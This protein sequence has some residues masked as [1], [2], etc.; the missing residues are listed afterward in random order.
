MKAFLLLLLC[1]LIAGAAPANAQSNVQREYVIVSG[2]PSLMKWEKWKIQPHDLW[3]LNF[4]RASRIRIQQLQAEGFDTAQITWFVYRPAYLSR[5]KQEGQDLI[6]TITSVR[7]AYG[8]NLRF[9]DRPDELIAYLN[10]G[11]PRDQVKIAGFE[12]FGHSNKACFLFDYSNVIDSGSKAWL[13]ED[14][15]SKIRR[16]IFTR[17]AFA[18]SWGCHTAES[19]SQKFRAATGI[20]MWGAVGKSQYNTHE[21]P[22]LASPHGRWKY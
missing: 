4:I 5:G 9:F 19:M 18:K 16:G 10:E 2:G 8:V 14:D 21:L 6:P 15:L 12:Y 3:W 22:S 11:K 20:K 17:D 1:A 13:H 7:D